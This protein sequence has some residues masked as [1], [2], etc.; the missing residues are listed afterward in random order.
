MGHLRSNQGEVR[1][2][3]WGEW[4]TS[5]G[6]EGG[7]F[8]QCGYTGSLGSKHFLE[9]LEKSIIQNNMLSPKHA[10][11]TANMKYNNILL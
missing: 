2:L 8:A 11:K 4:G 10:K 9:S 5:W 1:C 3:E 7:E 6:G